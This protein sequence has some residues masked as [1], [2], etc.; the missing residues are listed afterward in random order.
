MPADVLTPIRTRFDPD[1]PSI[2]PLRVRTYIYTR[3]QAPS[4]TTEQQKNPAA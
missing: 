3:V 1:C 4:C 2:N